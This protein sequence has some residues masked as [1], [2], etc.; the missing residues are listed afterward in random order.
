MII[1]YLT[2]NT[3]YPTDVLKKADSMFGAGEYSL[4][5]VWG[6]VTNSYG[7]DSPIY[8]E[9]FNEVDKAL[10]NGQ[11]VMGWY[12]G[13]SLFTVSHHFVVL[14]GIAS[15]GK[16]LVNDPSEG[17]Y[18]YEKSVQINRHYSLEEIQRGAGYW[19]IYPKKK[20]N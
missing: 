17:T 6:E 10:R 2:G 1:S 9:D 15:D 14:R 4:Y 16:Y 7:Y 5:N 3:I 11:P 12:K 8:T 19:Y 20:C 18:Y 13:D